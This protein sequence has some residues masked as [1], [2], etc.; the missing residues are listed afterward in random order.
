MVALPLLVFVPLL[1]P[2]LRL[3]VLVI[4][5]MRSPSLRFK[6]AGL[7]GLVGLVGL[8]D[9]S[10]FSTPYITPPFPSAIAF[11]SVIRGFTLAHAAAAALC[12]SRRN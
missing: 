3:V 6:L 5:L 9:A 1:F 10:I 4:T 7:A 2:L 11:I 8:T 12:D